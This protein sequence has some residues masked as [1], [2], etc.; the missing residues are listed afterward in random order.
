MATTLLRPVA[1]STSSTSSTSSTTLSSSLGSL[2]GF[3]TFASTS[4]SGT[5]LTPS[6][7]CIADVTADS[8]VTSAIVTDNLTATC[9]NTHGSNTTASHPNIGAILGCVIGGFVAIC[10]LGLLLFW[11]YRRRRRDSPDR[12]V[13]HPSWS[14]TSPED[15]RDVEYEITPFPHPDSGRG[16]HHCNPYPSTE[17]GAGAGAG[18]ASSSGVG[19]EKSYFSSPVHYS[20][21]TTSSYPHSSRSPSGERN[22]PF[23]C[24]ERPR[25]DRHKLRPSSPPGHVIKEK[26]IG[27]HQELDFAMEQ[28]VNGESSSVVQ[29]QDAGCVLSEVGL[30]RDVPPA[31]DSI[32]R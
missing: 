23:V 21:S 19:R 17:A 27:G 24:P 18:A 15:D 2:N 14:E 6:S 7:M 25:A 20:D 9:Q 1:F 10:Y 16:V 22:K 30:L 12:A 26:G 13:S 31:Y 5:T 32:I 4:D 3:T 11:I 8:Q 29:H 28:Q